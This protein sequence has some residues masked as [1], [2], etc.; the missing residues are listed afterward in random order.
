MKRINQAHDE[1]D[2]AIASFSSEVTAATQTCQQAV[3]ELRLTA[4]RFARLIKSEE[5][6]EQNDQEKQ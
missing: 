4:E 1:L 6:T 3:N 5:R 2:K